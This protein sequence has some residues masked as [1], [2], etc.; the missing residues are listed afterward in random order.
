M[1]AAEHSY[2]FK[3][4]AKLIRD[5]L[6]S[7]WMAR[8]SF[9]ACVNNVYQNIVYNTPQNIPI[10]FFKSQTVLIK[11]VSPQAAQQGFHFYRKTVNLHLLKGTV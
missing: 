5:L 4:P 10:D 11:L 8:L 3:L 7:N 2:G 6:D 1:T 9:D